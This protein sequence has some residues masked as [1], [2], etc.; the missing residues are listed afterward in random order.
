M[1]NS[2]KLEEKLRL[3]IAD[4]PPGDRLSSEPK[5]A[6]QLGVS[7]ATLR[8]AMRI[9]ETEGVIYRRQGVGTFVVHPAQVM[10]TGLERLQSIH[11]LA[12]AIDL[13]VEMG[14]YSVIR[15]L[16]TELELEKLDMKTSEYVSEVIW[17]MEAAGRP[18]A[19]LVDVLPEDVLAVDELENYFNGSVLDLLL[20]R[21]DL[22]LTTSRTSINAVAAKSPIAKSLGIQRRDVLLH[23]EALLYTVSGRVV[24]YS[25]SYYLPGYFRFHVVRRVGR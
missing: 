16:P 19:Y 10:E 21:G 14:D 2:Q 12:D 23:F 17:V 9:F 25:Y 6:A 15:R 7:R 4:T 24:D 18:V 11:S 1:S 13:K 22:K 3:I 8:E 20:R 5:L